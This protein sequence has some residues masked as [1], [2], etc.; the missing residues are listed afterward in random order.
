MKELRD[1]LNE[2]TEEQLKEIARHFC[3]SGV[4]MYICDDGFIGCRNKGRSDWYEDEILGI[5]N[6]SPEYWRDSLIEWGIYND[7]ANGIDEDADW[8]VVR[9]FITNDV[10]T[11]FQ[12]SKFEF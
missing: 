8:D 9:N 4:E 10:F 5:V 7:E 1:V 6:L 12:Y 11:A 2:L 3:W